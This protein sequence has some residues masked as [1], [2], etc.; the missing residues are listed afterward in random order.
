MKH[1]GK[2]FLLVSTIFL[3]AGVLVACGNDNPD[4]EG[5]FE[6][7]GRQYIT[8]TQLKEDI[9]ASVEMFLLDI[10]IEEQFLDGHLADAVLVPASPV[11]DDAQREMVGAVLPQVGASPLI[12]VCAGGGG[13][14]NNAWDYLESID[15]DMSSVFILENG[16]NGWPYDELVVN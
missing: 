9:E 7:G 4:N 11:D 1:M 8:A 13:S 3:I 2:V 15:Y 16:Q 14:A 6:S 10:R 5:T 12:I